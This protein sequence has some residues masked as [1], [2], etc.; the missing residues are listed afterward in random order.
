MLIGIPKFLSGDILKVLSDMGH[1]DELAIVDANFPASRCGQ[2]VFEFPTS[3]AEEMLAAVLQV[4]PLD[5]LE[6]P[7]AHLMAVAEG[8]LC[9]EPPIWSAFIS[10]ISAVGYSRAAGMLERRAFY[11]R[12]EQAF[13]IIRT[14]EG[15]LYGNIIVRKGVVR[16]EDPWLENQEL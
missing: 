4:M 5:H 11:E 10:Q 16:E 9:E 3:G 13:A 7:A 1:G 8:D 12:A 14:G 15:A 2:R 6:G